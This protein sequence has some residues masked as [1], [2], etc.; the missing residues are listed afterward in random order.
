LAE[1]EAAG[2]SLRHINEAISAETVVGYERPNW[3]GAQVS[4][5]ISGELFF[6]P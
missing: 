6:L 2:L 3:R 5:G 1:Q 4:H